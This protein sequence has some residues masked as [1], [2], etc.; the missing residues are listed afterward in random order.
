[1]MVT[2]RRATGDNDSDVDGDGATG[3]KV[4]D[5][6]D[7]VTDDDNDDNDDGNDNGD[8]DDGDDDY[9]GDGLRRR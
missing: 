3:S 1:M 4:D 7:S 6:G 8:N 2:A 5:N 9:D